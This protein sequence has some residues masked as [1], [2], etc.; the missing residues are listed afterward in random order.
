MK[1]YTYLSID[2]LDKIKKDE[3]KKIKEN[4]KGIYETKGFD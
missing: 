3:M 1:G 2:E 4:Y